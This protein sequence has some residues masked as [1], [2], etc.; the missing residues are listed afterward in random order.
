MTKTPSVFV[1]AHWVF[2]FVS[3]FVLRISDF[4]RSGRY[5]FSACFSGTT[6]TLTL[7][8]MS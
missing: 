6:I 1:I 5:F 8:S 7:V 2:E 3:N 4:Q